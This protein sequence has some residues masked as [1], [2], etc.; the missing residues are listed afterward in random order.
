M[1]YSSTICYNTFPFPEISEAQKAALA[2]AAKQVIVARERHSE[3]TLADLYDPDDMPDHLRAAHAE[4]DRAADR[5]YRNKPFESD[6][7][8]LQVL[9]EMYEEVTR[10]DAE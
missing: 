4:L 3:K 9:F 2:E 6:E 7:E 5:C 8:R 1:R 10:A